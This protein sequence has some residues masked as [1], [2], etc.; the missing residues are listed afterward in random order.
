MNLK[1]YLN[2]LKS[3]IKTTTKLLLVLLL[4]QFCPYCIRAQ[5]KSFESS[6]ALDTSKF[7]MKKSPWG[8]VLRSAVLPGFGQFYNQSYWKIPV[9]L[10][11]IGYL[12]YQWKTNNDS[13]KQYKSLYEQSQS[14]ENKNGNSFYKSNREFFRDQRDLFA[15]FL[16]LAYFLNLV[17]AYVDAQLFDFNV[18]ENQFGPKV[19]LSVQIKF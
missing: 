11:A 5:E 9:V 3:L 8:A 10:G 18:E 6:A 13:Y 7:E 2:Y 12:G 16:G 17:D 4:L 1:D 14:G 19:Q 15:V